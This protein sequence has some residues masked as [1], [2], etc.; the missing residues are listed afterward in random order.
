[1]GSW[2]T[3]SLLFCMFSLSWQCQPPMVSVQNSG[4]SWDYPVDKTIV[5]RANFKAKVSREPCNGENK[6]RYQWSG[7]NENETSMTLWGQNKPSFWRNR[8]KFPL[9]RYIMC[10]NVTFVHNTNITTQSCG[11]FR[12]FKPDP[13]I[14]LE[15]PVTLSQDILDGIFLDARRTSDPMVVTG[16]H[17]RTP[18]SMMPEALT[19]SWFCSID[20]ER[21][22]PSVV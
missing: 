6:V 1:M 22:A 18:S 21:P 8:F 15:G 10:I 2:M 4:P 20:V 14:I 12:F 9:G 19:Y 7:R 5:R 3:F 11:Y 16:S 17:P 13:S